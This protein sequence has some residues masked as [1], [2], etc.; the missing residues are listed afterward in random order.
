MNDQPLGMPFNQV[1]QVD[2]KVGQTHDVKFLDALDK[3]QLKQIYKNE[4]KH[5][6]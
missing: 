6:E 5:Q 3:E 1:H 4:I 2:E